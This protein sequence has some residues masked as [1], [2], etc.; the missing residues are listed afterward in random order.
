MTRHQVTAGGSAGLSQ[1][2]GGGPVRTLSETEFMAAARRT[3][4]S[5]WKNAA[6]RW[7]YHSAAIECVARVAPARARD[8]LELGTMGISIVH[9]SDTMDYAE[10][11]NG[12]FEPTYRHDARDMPWPVA[13]GRYDVF[14]A[15][16]VFHHLLPHQAAC[17]RE[18][19]RIARAIIIVTP[20]EYEVASLSDTSTGIAEADVAAWNDGVPPTTCMRFGDWRGNLYFWDATALRPGR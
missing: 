2:D 3:G 1:G 14:V 5:H 12:H 19:R 4:G 11:W 7:A 9:G 17:F 13:D 6:S 8:V 18:A 10:K 20:V 16:R 15:L